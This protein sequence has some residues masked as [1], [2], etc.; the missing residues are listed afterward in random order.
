[1]AITYNKVTQEVMNLLAAVAGSNPA[2]ADSNY[3]AAP[4]PATASGPDFV[5]AHVLDAIVAC[6]GEIVEAIASTPLNPERGRYAD[7][8]TSLA[9]RAAIPQ[10]GSGT[11]KLIIG[12]P[13]VVRDS[14]DAETLL[15]APLDAIRNF[16]RFASTVYASFS[17]YLYSIHAGQIEH[18]R[19]SVIIEVCVYERPTS[20]NGNIDL[21][22]WHEGGL[23]QGAVAKLA[24][25][26]SMF[27]DLYQGASAAWAGHLAEIRNYGNAELYGKAAAAPATT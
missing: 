23:V 25:K 12:V 21:N 13:G 18:T 8:T 1:M 2:S 20:L 10:T 14:A 6:Q 7:V 17:A 5:P 19:P 15:D 26:E 4:S 9:N 27:G 3:T 24:L 11:G 22:D 16:N